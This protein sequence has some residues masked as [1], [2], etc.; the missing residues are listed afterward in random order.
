MYERNIGYNVLREVKRV[1]PELRVSLPAV[2]KVK[3]PP[4][5]KSAQDAVSVEAK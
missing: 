1:G 3:P 4:E 5:H 2:E